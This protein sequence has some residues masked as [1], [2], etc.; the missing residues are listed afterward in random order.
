MV[1]ESQHMEP[2]FVMRNRGPPHFIDPA[3]AS[4]TPVLP[5]LDG[6]E[7]KEILVVLAHS[8]KQVVFMLKAVRLKSGVHEYQSFRHVAI[9]E[10]PHPTL[11]ERE[12]ACWL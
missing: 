4:S 10:A 11:L 2:V 12:T 8:Q 3:D 1:K 9:Q 6:I 7:V 5:P